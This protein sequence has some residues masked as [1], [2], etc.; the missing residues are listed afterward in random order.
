MKS[1]EGEINL[2]QKSAVFFATEQGSF[3]GHPPTNYTNGKL[4]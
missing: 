4:L 2:F 3:I 1:K